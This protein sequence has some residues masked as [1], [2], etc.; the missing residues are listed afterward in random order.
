MGRCGMPVFN[1]KTNITAVC[2]TLKQED[3]KPVRYYQRVILLS[4]GGA[5]Y[6]EDSC[7][8]DKAA[9]STVAQGSFKGSSFI[10][11]CWDNANFFLPASIP[12]S[13]FPELGDSKG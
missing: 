8:G 5:H 12:H 13:P 7:L 6:N 3:K 10:A 2:F 1:T 4:S 11:H 9:L